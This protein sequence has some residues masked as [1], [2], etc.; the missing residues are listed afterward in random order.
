MNSPMNSAPTTTRAPVPQTLPQTQGQ[1]T[2]GAGKGPDAICKSSSH[3]SRVVSLYAN[4]PVLDKLEHKF[5]GARF[6]DPANDAKNRALN[7]NIAK[8]LMSIG[9]MI[10][11]VWSPTFT[12]RWLTSPKEEVASSH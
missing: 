5:G 7:Q 4:T 9:P 10:L 12:S 1:R 11:Y 8:R 6:N 3:I 2:G